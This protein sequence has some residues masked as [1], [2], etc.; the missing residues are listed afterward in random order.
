MD[1][2]DSVVFELVSEALQIIRGSINYG[3]ALL[4]GGV[5]KSDL[6]GVS[7]QI[8]SQDCAALLLNKV[9]LS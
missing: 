9:R 3:E 8:M 6:D 2:E 5:D 7:E 1:M 4:E